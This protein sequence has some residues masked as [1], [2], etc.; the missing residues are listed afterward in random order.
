ME[1]DIKSLTTNQLLAIRSILTDG[2]VAFANKSET[3]EL[4]ELREYKTRNQTLNERRVMLAEMGID[5]EEDQTYWVEL[6]PAMF[7]FV[8]HT[9]A[10][11]CHGTAQAE[12]IKIPRMVSP[13]KKNAFETALRGLRE[14][15]GDN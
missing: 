7:D 2:E 6:T 14:R 4:K 15:R 9:L 1:L 10:T 3:A 11:R 12:T 8:C 5:I 13:P